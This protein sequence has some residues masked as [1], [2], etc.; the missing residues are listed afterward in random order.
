MSDRRNL[1]I[2]VFDSGVGGLTVMRAIADLLPHEHLVY[3]GDTARVPY[4]NR[5]SDTVRR[6]ALNA[7]NLLVNRGVKAI[8]VACNTA[9]AYAL[10]AVNTHFDVPVIGV[11]DPV[12]ERAAAQTTSG[13]IGVIGTRGTVRS[14]AYVH[15]LHRLDPDLAVHQVPCPLFVPLAE[16]GWTSGEVVEQ[17]AQKYLAAFD[18]VDIDAMILGCTHYPLLRGAIGDVI[19]KLLA[20][21]VDLLDSAS[22]TATVLDAQLVEH[23]LVRPTNGPRTLRFLLTDIPDGFRPTAERFFGDHI[24]AL[25]HVDIVDVTNH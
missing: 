24:E 6:Y 10:E 13:T 19:E 7:T 9:S 12:A 18:G 16:E 5:G 1:P 3:L 14:E 15:A 17:V 20:Q 25:E 21:P 2:G 8:V 23:D 4:G 11:I 22:A